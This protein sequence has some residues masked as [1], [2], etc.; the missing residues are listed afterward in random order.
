[1]L[2]YLTDECFNGN[3]CHALTSRSPTLDIV[4]GAGCRT[5]HA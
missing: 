1:M 5:G 4:R 3:L 2:R